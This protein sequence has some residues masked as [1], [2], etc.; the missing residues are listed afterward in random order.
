MYNLHPKVLL[1]YVSFLCVSGPMVGGRG[2]ALL[3]S[4]C[5]D[6][7]LVDWD[8]LPLDFTYFS[9]FTSLNSVGGN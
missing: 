3:W 5:L 4:L 2:G 6:S 9:S 8:W 1:A 7:G